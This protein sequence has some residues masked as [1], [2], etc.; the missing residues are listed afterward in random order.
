[1]K[2][3][4]ASLLSELHREFLKPLGFKKH[5]HTLSRDRETYVERFNFQGSASSSS[6]E[7]R[8]YLNVGIEF[9]D[10]EPG[11]RNWVYFPNTH[12]AVRVRELVDG[13]PE[14][15]DCDE[16]TDCG[17]LKR[18]LAQLIAKASESLANCAGE[19]RAIHTARVA[20]RSPTE[21]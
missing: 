3:W 5:R 4:L 15:W 2:D 13:A 19:F 9:S 6:Q 10:L 20:G 17:D 8:F 18:Q 16:S 11:T 1:L 14:H 21:V 12:W 7:K